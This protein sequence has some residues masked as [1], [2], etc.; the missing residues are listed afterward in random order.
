MMCDNENTPQTQGEGLLDVKKDF[1]AGDNDVSSD[2]NKHSGVN[3][4]ASYVSRLDNSAGVY[5]MLDKDGHVL[6][7]GKA[8]SLKKRVSNYTQ[9]DRN[10][11]RIQRMISL[12]CGMEFVITPSEA[13]A[14]LLEASLIKSLKPR[15]N[16][17]LRDDKSFPDILIRTEHEYP[18]IIKHR[19]KRDKDKGQYFGPF[20]SVSAVNDTIE[21]L[22]RAFLLRDCTDHTF[23]S[24]ERPCLQY[25]IK[26]C[27]A[28]C[29]GKISD[30]DYQ[31]SVKQASDFLKGRSGDIIAQLTDDM[32][33]CAESMDYERAGMLRDRI[34]ALS[35]VQ[36]GT[37]HMV[38]VEDADVFAIEMT[39]GQ[40]C[41]QVFF[42]RGGTSFG[43]RA[44]YPAHDK[45]MSPSGILESFIGQFYQNFECP[46][47]IL[48][49]QPLESESVL[50]EALSISAEKRVIV[51]QPKRGDKAKA[52]QIATEN[53][54]QSLSR[55][56]TER[57]SQIS[58][59]NGVR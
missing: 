6:Y 28:P 54:K 17:L 29:V 41:V 48:V 42:Y 55:R 34:R 27:S 2:D 9:Y 1:F 23:A 56:M 40:S 47:E 20:A 33:K 50:S 13:E 59:V 57:S 10:S 16:V 39:G 4:I 53:A 46:S 15:Y 12:T 21:M 25:Q 3:I 45:D 37:S 19:G 52:V 35:T 22:Q 30:I 49:N 26:R 11:L 38:H 31:A 14:L 7:V 58:N 44:F 51:H 24:R 5:R 43:N 18:Q 32:Q 8:K 36:G